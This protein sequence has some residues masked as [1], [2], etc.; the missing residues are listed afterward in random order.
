MADSLISHR[1]SQGFNLHKSI[2]VRRRPKQVHAS[3]GNRTSYPAPQGRYRQIFPKL[4]LR[5][6]LLR[7]GEHWSNSAHAS[8]RS[9]L[10]YSRRS[11]SAIK[12]TF[13][14]FISQTKQGFSTWHRTL[15]PF[16]AKLPLQQGS[17]VLK[18]QRQVASE[19]KD[20][21]TIQ[22]TFLLSSPPAPLFLSPALLSLFIFFI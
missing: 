9:S 8:D 1:L 15:T 16:C 21:F 14:E 12:N 2:H 20:N 4:G 19:I 10:L 17:H 11:G 18:S 5:R 3:T 13:T 7:P 22:D 6:D